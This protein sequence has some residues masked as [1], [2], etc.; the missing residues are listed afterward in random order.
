MRKPIYNSALEEGSVLIGTRGGRS[1]VKRVMESPDPDNGI[2]VVDTE[3]GTIHLDPEGISVVL[4]FRE[5]DEAEQTL[6]VPVGSPNPVLPAPVPSF[7]HVPRPPHP[8]RIDENPAE[9]GLP[10]PKEQPEKVTPDAVIPPASTDNDSTPGTDLVVSEGTLMPPFQPCSDSSCSG[11]C[12]QCGALCGTGCPYYQA[13]GSDI[14]VH[15]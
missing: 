11:V 4:V 13:G 6:P 1:V 3:H 14:C 15:L 8:W 9:G 7:A 10:E 12:A 5:G 2:L